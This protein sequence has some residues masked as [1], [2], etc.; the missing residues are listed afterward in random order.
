MNRN[1][2]VDLKCIKHFSTSFSGIF[3]HICWACGMNRV[4]ALVA[5]V[6]EFG[7]PFEDREWD[8]GHRRE[9]GLIL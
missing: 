1:A 7:T 8:G 4:K 5:S 9:I 3:K 2:V 6:E